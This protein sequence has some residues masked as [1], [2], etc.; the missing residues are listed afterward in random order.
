MTEDGAVTVILVL[1]LLLYQFITESKRKEI[2]GKFNGWIFLERN[3]IQVVFALILV[4][5]LIGLAAKF[6]G[7]VLK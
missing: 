7:D 4:P 6:L 1:L 5:N 3:L 2:R